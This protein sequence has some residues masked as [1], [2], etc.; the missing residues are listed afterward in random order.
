MEEDARYSRTL[1]NLLRKGRE[2]EWIEYKHNNGDP[3]EIGELVSAL[4]NSAA[5]ED[6]ELGYIVW[7]VADDSMQVVGTTYD[8]YKLTNGQEFEHW[9]ST[10]CRPRLGLK[11]TVFLHEGRR[12]VMLEI[13]RAYREPTQFKSEAFVRVGSAKKKLAEH[14]DRQRILHRK[15]EETSFEDLAAKVNILP[16]DI[17]KFL[18]VE[19]Y[20][21][22]NGRPLPDRFDLILENL[23]SDD[24]IKLDPSGHYSITNLGALLYARNFA[25]FKPLATKTARLILYPGSG[26]TKAI[27]EW[28]MSVGYA[29]GFE[30]LVARAMDAVRSR[31]EY[32]GARRAQVPMFPE[33]AVREIIANAL[34]HQD[35]SVRGLGVT[36]EIFSNRAEFLNPGVPELETNRFLDLRRSRNEALALNMRRLS[37]CEERGSGIDKVLTHVEAAQ[38]PA[39]VFRGESNQTQ[40]VLFGP[41]TLEEMSRDE[42]IKACYW[43]AALQYVSGNA[44][45]NTT[46]RKRLGIGE[47]GIAKA[48]RLI[49]DA[50]QAEVIKLRD[51]TASNKNKSYVPYWA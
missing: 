19:A 4:S 44:M 17:A 49:S 2:C 34:I 51:A 7:G 31:E 18:D 15:F 8:P 12:V 32:V 23:E 42:R 37:F 40:V 29:C 50:V 38:L 22:L 39:P 36:I 33:L 41:R 47:R 30:E 13:D 5:I 27:G 14:A 6:Q 26:R 45:T 35:L 24:L 1:G 46:L 3:R 11:F 43:H 25:D 21:R 9:L 10:Q 16:I 28:V 48:S 20:H